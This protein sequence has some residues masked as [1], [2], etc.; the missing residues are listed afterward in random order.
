MYTTASRTT[1]QPQRSCEPA[2]DYLCSASWIKIHEHSSAQSCQLPTQKGPCD[3]NSQRR[4]PSSNPNRETHDYLLDGVVLLSHSRSGGHFTKCAPCNFQMPQSVSTLAVSV[5]AS[6]PD[7]IRDTRLLRIVLFRQTPRRAG[8]DKC[9][10]NMYG[11]GWDVSRAA[12]VFGFGIE[13]EP[14]CSCC[15]TP[16]PAPDMNVYYWCTQCTSYFSELR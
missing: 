12:A 14:R 7:E 9:M 4:T 11:P 8:E 16:S 15:A 3:N 10:Y 1:W 13:W 6:P 5:R 2:S